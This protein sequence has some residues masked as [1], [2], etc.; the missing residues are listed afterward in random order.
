M[1]DNSNDKRCPHCDG[2]LS[3]GGYT[4]TVGVL[5]IHER[6]YDEWKLKQLPVKCP[7]CKG[8]GKLVTATEKKY[9]CCQGGHALLG[10]F[11]GSSGCE[12][13]SNIIVDNV[14]IAYKTCDLCSGEGR[15]E[16]EPTPITQVVGWKK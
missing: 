9:S 14:P 11:A 2:L 5:C 10:T 16:K 15:L 7:Q 3:K 12:Y 8:S 1:I 6:C 13:C 4:R